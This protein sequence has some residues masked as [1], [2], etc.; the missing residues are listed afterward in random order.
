MIRVVSICAAV[1]LMA[2]L[3]YGAGGI[4]K[5]AG[6]YTVEMSLDKNPPVVGKNTMDIGLKDAS[7]KAVTDAK[8]TVEYS[9]PAMPGMPA[10]NYKTEAESKREAYRAIISPSMAGSWNVAIR[11]VRAGKAETARFTID[12]K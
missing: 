3:V 10:M 12:V 2:G 8:L 5:K 9:M 4:T 7:G 6:P 1:L 11:I